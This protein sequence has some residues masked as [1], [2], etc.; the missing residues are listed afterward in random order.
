MCKHIKYHGTPPNEQFS[1][2]FLKETI[3][4]SKLSKTVSELR[5]KQ[6]TQ[7]LSHGR[8]RLSSAY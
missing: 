5:Y 8:L 1:H 2:K 3:F 4:P 7:R 6:G